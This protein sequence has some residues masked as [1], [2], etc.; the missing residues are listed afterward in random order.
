V[1]ACT[2]CGAGS[3]TN[4]G[5]SPGAMLC[6]ECVA[7]KYQDEVAQTTCLNCELGQY[8]DQTG[9]NT[10]LDCP[11]GRFSPSTGKSACLVCPCG[12]FSQHSGSGACTDGCEPGFY[13]TNGVDCRP[14]PVGS[15]CPLGI[16][17]PCEG[18]TFQDEREQIK[19]KFCAPGSISK[20]NQTSC[21]PCKKGRYQ[22]QRGQAHC[23]DWSLLHQ[24]KCISMRFL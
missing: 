21:T 19:C 15:A 12:L 18:G 24:R 6:T 13:T 22:K 7:G 3:I 23:N 11:K 1:A 17:Q 20:H 8:S 10:C 4:T 14:C 9:R 2:P 16:R 5:A